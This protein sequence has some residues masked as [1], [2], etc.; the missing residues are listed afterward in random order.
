MSHAQ[1][2]KST[3]NLTEP[4]MTDRRIT[5]QR[6]GEVIDDPT[7]RPFGAWLQEQ[8]S[9]ATHE[10]LSEGLWDLTARV[11]ETGK[12]GTLTLIV[13][14]EPMPKTDGQVLVVTD[15]I[16]LKLPEFARQGSVFYADR[17]GNLTRTNP[18]QPELTGLRE[19]PAPAVDPTTI[20]EATKS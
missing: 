13:T 9:G 10:E 14:V 17:E 18:D 19:V 15:E 16:R 20:K 3:N 5:D 1:P 12:K 7:I 11:R 4:H 6:T 8:S 2:H